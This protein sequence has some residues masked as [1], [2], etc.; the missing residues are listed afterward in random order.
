MHELFDSAGGADLHPFDAEAAHLHLTPHSHATDT[1]GDGFSDAV[2]IR[3]GTDPYDAVS[4]PDLAFDG[5]GHHLGVG[6]VAHQGAY[7]DRD[8]DGFPDA[9][10]ALVHTDPF[11][12]TSHPDVVFAHHFPA[13][14][15]GNLPCSLD[16]S[17][18]SL[19]EW[20]LP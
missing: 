3:L 6:D 10:E 9:L 5:H 15:D 8:G 18:P 2:E 16:V 12:A 11:Q 4:H 17:L 13:G 14:T 20:R 19:P 7:P 1:D